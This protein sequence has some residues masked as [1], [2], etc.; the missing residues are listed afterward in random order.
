[1]HPSSSQ[2]PRVPAGA[3][4]HTAALPRGR[5]ERIVGRLGK[6]ENLCILHRGSWSGWLPAGLAERF[7]RETHT[8]Q[9][10]TS[11][12]ASAEPSPADCSCSRQVL[13]ATRESSL[14][15][16]LP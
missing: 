13:A 1:M 15:L 16:S 10:W 12:W 2:P 14:P 6:K 4:A 5:I 9:L 7:L 8:V 11:V 3:L